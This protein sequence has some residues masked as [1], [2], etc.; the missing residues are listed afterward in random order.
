MNPLAFIAGN[1]QR[2]AAYGVVAIFALSAAAAFGYHRGVKKLWDYQV[3]QAKEAVKVVVKQGEVTERVVTKFIKGQERV[4][5]ITNTIEKEVVRYE[6]TTNCLDVRWGRLHD[7]AAT[8]TLP[9]APGPADA[10]AGAPTAFA[11]IET[12]SSNYAAC[13]RNTDK[14]TALQEWLAEQAKVKP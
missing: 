13:H 14:L 12:V 5:I 6:N 4:R 9:T 2:F 7:A 3:E 11:S 1:W 8:R 10:A